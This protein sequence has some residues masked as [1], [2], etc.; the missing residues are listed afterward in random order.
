VTPERT[1]AALGVIHIRV[2]L[3]RTQMTGEPYQSVHTERHALE[4]AELE[5]LQA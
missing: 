4:R 5:T 2:G 1:A 3:G